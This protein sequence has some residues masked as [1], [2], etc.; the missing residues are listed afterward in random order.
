[1]AILLRNSVTVLLKTEL[2]IIH[3]LN[4]GETS[5]KIR[6]V[7]QCRYNKRQYKLSNQTH[8]LVID[9]YVVCHRK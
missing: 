1:M 2:L 6:C 4:G 7:S 3:E 8:F 9:T 5:N